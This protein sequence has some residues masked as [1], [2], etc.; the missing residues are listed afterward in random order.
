VSLFRSLAAV[1]FL[2]PSVSFAEVPKSGAYF[3]YF[4]CYTS[5]AGS[6][7]IYRAELD[8]KTGKLSEPELA[9][10]VKSPSFV[11]ISADGKTLYAVGEA[12]GEDGGP[13]YSYKID[14]AT[15]KL[16]DQ[17]ALTSGS[18]GPCHIST[19]AA[20]TIAVAS[21][22]GGGSY[23]FFSLKPDGSLDKRIAHHVM[24]VIKV[25]DKDKKANGH[26]CFFDA[27]GTIAFGCNLG[28]DRVQLFR[29]TA[30]DKVVANDPPFI[31]FKAGTGPRHIHIAP[32]NDVAFV[33]G[34]LNMTVNV[35]KF[36]LKANK[37]EVAQTLSTVGKGD[38]SIGNPSTAEC[39]IH[40]SGKFVYVSNRGFNNLA[41]FAWDAAAGKL[42]AVGHITGDIK[43]PRNFNI[44]LDG[45]WM[46]IASQGGG[47]VGVY[48]IDQ[49]T[50]L[51]KETEN[52]V[53]IDKCVCVKFLAK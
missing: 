10:E 16:S 26:S 5:Q 52:S 42:T 45:R 48:E 21:N 18:A 29:K 44:T 30:T 36:D 35:V 12:A 17:V 27:T 33:C 22:Y 15:G 31:Q 49:A 20:G 8:A 53:K 23:A 50:G 9:A 51:A 41:A 39:R 14:P 19:D 6:K 38:K 3:V 24:P 40:P 34:E 47:K 32:D 11:H 25:N 2:L 4:G 37:Y 1:A 43:T 7:G 28:Q 13:V 46:L